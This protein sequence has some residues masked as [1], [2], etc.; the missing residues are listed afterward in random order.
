[1]HSEYSPIY[2]S[3]SQSDELPL[4]CVLCAKKTKHI[5]GISILV[6]QELLKSTEKTIFDNWPP[7][8]N[9]NWPE[10]LD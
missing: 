7:L 6:I 4:K 2:I 9:A 5:E 1:M 3:I 10:E 8:D